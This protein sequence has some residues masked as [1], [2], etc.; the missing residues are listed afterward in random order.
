M[1]S[2]LSQRRAAMN[3]L[4]RDPENEE[5]NFLGYGEET[6]YYGED[7]GNYY[8]EGLEEGDN[9]TG[10]AYYDEEPDASEAGR[11]Q[12]YYRAQVARMRAARA[13]QIRSARTRATRAR[14]GYVQRFPRVTRYRQT[15][16]GGLA[17]EPMEPS[18][19]Q[20][21]PV[22]PGEYPQMPTEPGDFSQMTT[23]PGDMSQTSIEPDYGE[24]WSD[25]A[26]YLPEFFDESEPNMF[27][28]A[29]ELA[30]GL[31]E[32]LHED[33]QDASPEQIQEA[34]FNMLEPMTPAEGFSFGKVLSQMGTAGK[35]LLKDPAVAQIAATVLPV[36][37]SALGT[38]VG[39]P[40]GTVIGGKLGQAAGQALAKGS[41]QAAPAATSSTSSPQGGSSAA[42][43]LLQLTQDPNLLK[44]LLS[45]A[46]GSSGKSS[47]QV[48][49]MEV[50]NGAFI[51]LLNVL[52]GKAAVDADKLAP[53][54]DGASEYL[55]DS[56][57]NFVYDPSVPEDRARALYGVLLAAQNQEL[58][59]ETKPQDP[60][61]KFFPFGR[62]TRLLV[63]YDAPG[64]FNPDI[65][66]GVVLEHTWNRLKV[67]IDIPQKKIAGQTVPETSAVFDVKYEM[68]G[69]GN[70]ADIVVNGERFTDKN[71]KIRSRGNTR[72]ILMSIR[73]LG[74][75]VDRISLSKNRAAEA[76]IKFKAE[77]KEYTLILTKL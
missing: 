50:P 59:A 75:E 30:E 43:Q 66:T 32:V 28:G 14:Y 18:G 73:I 52:T 45:L 68:E 56:E 70:Q 61:S 54:S 7:V 48:G 15:L 36:A 2:I 17:P 64:P 3:F 67:R 55:Q 26:D 74:Q 76:F 25:E 5:D 41:K 10:E 34:M 44:S 6:D 21:T 1:T 12:P 11:S 40:A 71:V 4:P 38:F 58:A 27:D 77:G 35:K 8:Y 47:V 13:A 33:Y 63:E 39:G 53:K 37:G 65:G 29:A 20:Q 72:D 57:G 42:T 22:E 19:V 24:M 62:E 51:N 31:R 46:L 23:E 69:A 9:D 16:P 60:W 49:K